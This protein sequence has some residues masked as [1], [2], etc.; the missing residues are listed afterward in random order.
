MMPWLSGEKRTNLLWLCLAVLFALGS[1]Y[2]LLGYMVTAPAHVVNELGGDTGKNYFTFIYHTLYGHGVWFDG[3]NYPY[4]DNVIYADGQPII[5]T[6]LQL[7]HFTD[8]HQALAAMNLLISFSYV[9]G[10]LFTYKSLRFLGTQAFLAIIFACLINLLS[11]QVLRLRGHFGMAY[12]FPLP[13]LFYYSMLYHNTKK[14]KWA[15]YI[16]IVGT[17]SA[18]IHLY[19]GILVLLL[20]AFYILWSLLIPFVPIFKGLNKSLAFRDSI[21]QSAPII[22][23][24]VVLFA[25]IKLFVLITDPF[26]DRPSFPVNGW[27]TVT[28]INEIL[29]STLSPFWQYAIGHLG[30][31]ITPYSGEGYV[32]IGLVSIIVIAIATTFGL[33]QIFHKKSTIGNLGQKYKFDP[34]WLL[35][36]ASTV[37]LGMGIPF[38]W[39]MK[40]LLNY[41]G[42]FKQFRSMGRFSWVFYYIISMYTVY[43]INKWFTNL[44]AKKKLIPAISLLVLS[45]SIWS[46]EVYGYIDYTQKIIVQGRKISAQ[47]FQENE[48]KWPE[49]LKSKNYKPTDFQAILLSPFFFSGTEKI[50]VGGDPSYP[51]SIG[52]IASIE[53]HLPLVDVMMSRSSWSVTEKQVKIGAGKYVDKPMLR[54]LKS[55]KPF[56]VIQFEESTPSPDEQYILES[57]DFIGQNYRTKIYACYP[58][59]LL[60]NFNKYN[61]EIKKIAADI[62]VNTDSCIIN[63]GTWHIKHFDRGLKGDHFF[64]AGSCYHI[65]TL[66]S[67]VADIP[68]NC[69]QENQLY[70]LSCWFLLDTK[71]FYS[72]Y[73]S[74]KLFD[75]AKQVG[76]YEAFTKESVD[77]DNMWFR[78][79]QFFYIKPNCKHIE[80]TLHD[81]PYLSYLSMDELML[82]PA[83]ALIVSKDINGKVMV[84]NHRVEVR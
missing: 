4:G 28:H 55:N 10:I 40:F 19:L 77:N 84:N 9:L 69:T 54:D 32:Y 23:T 24:M 79:N 70:E 12:V 27:D 46:I 7:L 71:N 43:L 8:A 61:K 83:D 50:W 5:S 74:I 72:P 18:F 78:T 60:A 3:M 1:T 20:L 48:Q 58:E 65:N 36:G 34:I 57:S 73:I 21:K 16:L 33:F 80:L 49:Y 29:S 64:G 52:M 42:I 59:R 56:L 26:T 15:L 47:F 68:I 37:V 66:D 30:Y 39:N 38:I 2:L 35:V 82:R 17:I 67:I 62:K 41:L 14:W 53:M 81:A 76:Y 6:A 63:K 13:M 45:I 25:F 11:P 51:M 31:T 22:A 75:S 44:Q